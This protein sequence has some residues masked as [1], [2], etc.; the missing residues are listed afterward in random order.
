MQRVAQVL[1]HIYV[2]LPPVSGRVQLGH[3]ALSGLLRHC[4]NPSQSSKNSLFSIVQL[5]ERFL[6]QEKRIMTQDAMGIN[7]GFSDAS[8]SLQDISIPVTLGEMSSK[9][10]AVWQLMSEVPGDPYHAKCDLC[11]KIISR[12]KV[13]G[14]SRCTTNMKLHLTEAHRSDLEQAEAEIKQ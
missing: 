2:V 1:R 5:N 10:S 7:K 12:G 8:H 14:K 13:G 11:G 9:R 4:S 6:Y 3:R